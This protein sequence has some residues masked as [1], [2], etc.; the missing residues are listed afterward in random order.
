ML[1]QPL[2]CCLLYQEF[3]TP[4]NEYPGER[5]VNISKS[6]SVHETTQYGSDYD[7]FW[8]RSIALIEQRQNHHKPINIKTA[9]VHILISSHLPFILPTTHSHVIPTFR[10]L[11]IVCLGYLT[12][13]DVF[14]ATL[15]TI[16]QLIE[17][18]NLKMQDS[19]S[20]IQI[21]V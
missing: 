2:G 18:E 12:H 19:I 10:L 7:D 4:E 1:L 21:G 5:V 9:H 11:S 14:G 15:P 8:C 16:F 6:K 20:N 3:D 17:R 13:G